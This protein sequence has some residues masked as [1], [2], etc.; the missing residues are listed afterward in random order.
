M[1]TWYGWILIGLWG[2]NTIVSIAKIGDARK[3]ISRSDAL[4]SLITSGL[5]VWGLLAIGTGHL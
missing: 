2:L 5:Y 4:V 1:I 3:P